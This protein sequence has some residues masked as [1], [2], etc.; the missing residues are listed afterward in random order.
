[1]RLGN[2]EVAWCRRSSATDCPE[3][4]SLLK[5]GIR[6]GPEESQMTTYH[7]L[8]SAQ[9][10]LLILVFITECSVSLV[11]CGSLVLRCPLATVLFGC[12][13]TWSELQ[14]TAQGHS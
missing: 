12:V 13:G 6:C 2:G 1:M 11:D 5:R 10:R 4:G 7:A 3:K 9:L 8:V 14:A